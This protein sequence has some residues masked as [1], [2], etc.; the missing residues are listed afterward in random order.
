M[1]ARNGKT[2]LSAKLPGDAVTRSWAG[3]PELGHA[4]ASEERMK[5]VA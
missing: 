1:G 2:L 4:E 3:M 5:T